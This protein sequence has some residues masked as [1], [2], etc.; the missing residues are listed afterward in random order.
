MASEEY[1]ELATGI[2]QFKKNL[3]RYMQDSQ[4]ELSRY[5]SWNH[6]YE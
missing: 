3:R 2:D 4:K 1:K 6:C 5:R